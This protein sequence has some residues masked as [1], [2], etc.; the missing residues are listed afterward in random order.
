MKNFTAYAETKKGV[1]INLPEN[2]MPEIRR[3]NPYYADH[4]ERI[5]VHWAFTNPHIISKAAKACGR[6]ARS[7]RV[8]C[9]EQIAQ[10]ATI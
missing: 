4:A 6:A 2:F 9:V 8:V 5:G 3:T 10:G 7:L 1:R